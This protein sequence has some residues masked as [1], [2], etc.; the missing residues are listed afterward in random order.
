MSSPDVW[1]VTHQQL[2]QYM[3]NPVPNTELSSQPYMQCNQNPKPPTNICNGVDGS[4]IQPQTC[5]LPDGIFRSCYGCPPQYPTLSNPAP[6]PIEVVPCP[7]SR[8]CDTKFWDSSS[9]KCLC[10]KPE[11]ELD[12]D[13]RPISLDP[14]SMNDRSAGNSKN[15]ASPTLNFFLSSIL[16]LFQM[17]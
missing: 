12:S 10:T 7:V 3:Q 11:C 2:L 5:P 16:V 17:F 13:A 4:T 9:C 8:T 6:Q 15:S 14:N 1:M